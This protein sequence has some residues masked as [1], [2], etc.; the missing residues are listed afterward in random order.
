M[1]KVPLIVAL[2]LGLVGCSLADNPVARW[3]APAASSPSPSSSGSP[4]SPPASAVPEPSA[5]PTA[6]PSSPADDIR[7]TLADA[8]KE[9]AS[10]VTR[11]NKLIKD[12]KWWDEQARADTLFAEGTR[13][14]VVIDRGHVSD[15]KKDRARKPIRLTGKQ[16]YYVPRNQPATGEWFMLQATY[17]GQDRA[18]LLAFWRAKGESFKLAAK[19]PLHYGQR[20]P[21]PRLDA[22]GYATAAPMST[23]GAIAGEYMIFWDYDRHK[24]AGKNGY[25]LAKDNFSR[26]AYARISKGAYVGYQ[27]FG[28]PWGFVA[29]D[30]GSVF[31]FSMLNHPKSIWQ[32]LTVATYVRKGS[33]EIQELAGD[34]YA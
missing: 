6:T 24:R 8:R 1:R 2:A 33:K 10:W 28:T 21:A 14:E 30:G 9:A 15:G 5:T 17:Q 23:G 34:W 4:A 11:H 31:M 3:A 12:R 22:E 16:T 13:H 27:S 29:R 26:K 19:T 20:V 32:V 18:H 7:L 25:R